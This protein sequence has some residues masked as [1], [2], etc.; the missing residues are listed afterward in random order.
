MY[1]GVGRAK[2]EDGEDTPALNDLDPEVTQ[3][4]SKQTPLLR[5]SHMAHVAARR[6]GYI[7]QGCV[8]EEK[9]NMDI[10]KYF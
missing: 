5:A 4:T 2:I 8:Q 9:E 10:G 3:I 7:I 6:M 1:A